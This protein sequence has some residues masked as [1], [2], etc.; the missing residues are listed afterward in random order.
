[1]SGPEILIPITFFLSAA[2]VIILRGPIGKAIAG[3][4]RQWS[5]VPPPDVDVQRLTAE[6]EELKHRLAEVEERQDFAERLLAQRRDRGELPS[7]R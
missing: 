7:G 3:L 4:I 5:D 1:M 6:L 2:A